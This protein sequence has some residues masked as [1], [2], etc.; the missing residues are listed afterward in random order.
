MV[1]LEIGE[2][3]QYRDLVY[4]ILGKCKHGDQIHYWVKCSHNILGGT[5]GNK[6]PCFRKHMVGNKQSCL[7]NEKECMKDPCKICGII[8]DGEIIPKLK[9]ILLVGE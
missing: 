3:V 4:K 2:Y 5:K 1:E 9:G 7:F 8:T 6:E